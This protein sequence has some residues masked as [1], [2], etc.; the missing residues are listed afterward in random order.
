MSIAFLTFLCMCKYFSP[1]ITLNLNI[2]FLVFFTQQYIMGM[3]A[4]KYI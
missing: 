4:H 1:K 2:L 3:F